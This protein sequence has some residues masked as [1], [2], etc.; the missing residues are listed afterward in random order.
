M[1]FNASLEQL[2]DT[3]NLIAT[4]HSQLNSFYQ[5]EVWDITTK[6]KENYPLL[7]VTI[8]PANLALQTLTYNF[9]LYCMD[10]VYPDQKNEVEVKSDMLSVMWDIPQ[11]LDRNFDL[12]ITYNQATPL[13]ES[14]DDV[15][16]GW[17]MD[18]AIE[19]PRTY[20]NCDVPLK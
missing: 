2:V 19:T 12:S 7:A 8:L 4:N 14:L 6:V 11:L 15:V 17:Y 5:G 13:E 1:G 16:A 3:F 20:T 9:R 18:I 10:L